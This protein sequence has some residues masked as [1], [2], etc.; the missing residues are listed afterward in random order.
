MK[1]EL[2]EIELPNQEPETFLGDEN[3]DADDEYNGGNSAEKN[4]YLNDLV[5]VPV[6][7]QP[8]EAGVN[9]GRCRT[10]LIMH[11]VRSVPVRRQ[12]TVSPG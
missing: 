7:V 2:L 5:D 4:K 3:K 9:A 12:L 8:V 1:E 10:S 6:A 11:G